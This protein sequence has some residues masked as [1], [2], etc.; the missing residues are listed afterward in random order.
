MEWPLGV[1]IDDILKVETSA[2]RRVLF[3]GEEADKIAS[4]VAGWIAHRGAT[5]IVLDGANQFSPYAISALARRMLIPAE[6]I[7]KKILIARA[8][9]CYQMTTLVREKLPCWS[10]KDNPSPL[11]SSIIV[12]GPMDTFL[13]EDIRNEESRIL[14]DRFIRTME[15][16]SFKTFR[17][18][19]FQSNSYRSGV[20]ASGWQIGEKKKNFTDQRELY[21]IKRLIQFSDSLWRTHLAEG[22][23]GIVLERE[24]VKNN[25]VNKGYKILRR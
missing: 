6:K 14:F 18:L 1:L 12:M 24:W 21:F 19:L 23:Q 8:F 16:M 9:T 4:Y 5:V 22:Q 7:L 20:S 17:F 25:L 13:D 15:K 11:R 3:W 10:T 2:P